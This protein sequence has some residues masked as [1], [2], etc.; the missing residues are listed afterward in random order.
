L[1]LFSVQVWGL[2][3]ALASTGFLVG[4]AIIGKVGLGRNPLRTMLLAVAVMGLLGAM[5]TI[6][7]WGWLYLVG[8]WLY[9]AIFPA[10]EAA[11]QTVIQRVVPLER[12][13][14]VF[15]FAGAVEAAAAPVTAF[16]VA[17]IA[18]FW[19]IPWAR[20][21]SGADALA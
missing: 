9:M 8:I 11:E 2:L 19:I 16:L 5:F 21:T 4:G 12:Q 7:E 1:E 13:G 6:R 10:V 17:P 14:R 15:G 20:S 18:E 3:F